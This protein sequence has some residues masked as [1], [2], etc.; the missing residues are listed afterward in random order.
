MIPSGGPYVGA[1]FRSALT[2]AAFG[3]LIDGALKGTTT[4]YRRRARMRVN[5]VFSP[6]FTGVGA[7]VTWP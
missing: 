6:R 7:T 2:G 4:V 1:V 3:A 5:G